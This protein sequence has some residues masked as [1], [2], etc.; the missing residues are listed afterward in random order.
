MAPEGVGAIHT[1]PTRRFAAKSKTRRPHSFNRGYKH[2]PVWRKF[3]LRIRD[4]SVISLHDWEYNFA[5]PP[6]KVYLI[7]QLAYIATIVAADL[8]DSRIDKMQHPPKGCLFDETE[9]ADEFRVT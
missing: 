2:S 1:W 9:G 3:C 7:Y 4:R 8:T 5:P 6:V